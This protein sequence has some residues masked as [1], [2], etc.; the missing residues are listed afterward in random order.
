METH[1][2]KHLLSDLGVLKKF[3]IA[4]KISNAEIQKETKKIKKIHKNADADKLYKLLVDVLISKTKKMVEDKFP[5]GLIIPE[6]NIKRD[7]LDKFYTELMVISQALCNKFKEE[8]LSTHQICFIFN[9]MINILGITEEDF[10]KFY[11]KFEK[12]KDGDYSDD[13]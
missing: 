2:P 4:K 8:K 1:L 3:S 7:K 9:A 6:E 5:P 11:E 13:E 12:Y 10:L